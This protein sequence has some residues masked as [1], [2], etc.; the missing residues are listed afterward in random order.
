MPRGS[1]NY[2]IKIKPHKFINA[3]AHKLAYEPILH[4]LSNKITLG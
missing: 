1:D 3:E 2:F 4:L